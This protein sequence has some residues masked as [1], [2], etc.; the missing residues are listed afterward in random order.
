MKEKDEGRGMR[1]EE[2]ARPPRQMEFLAH[3]E[4]MDVTWLERTLE[5]NRQWLFASELLALA[6]IPPTENEKRWLRDLASRSGWIISGGRG[7]RHVRHATGEEIHR[8]R[9]ALLHQAR[10]VCRRVGRVT[11]NAHTIFGRDQ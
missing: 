10:E 1:D 3:K 5:E 7:Y 6:G 9:A 4:D 8:F 2:G 11:R